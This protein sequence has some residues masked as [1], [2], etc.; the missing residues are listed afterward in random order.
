MGINGAK[1]FAEMLLGDIFWTVLCSGGSFHV[2]SQVSQ[3]SKAKN[4]LHHD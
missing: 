3:S 1:H 2:I 4:I